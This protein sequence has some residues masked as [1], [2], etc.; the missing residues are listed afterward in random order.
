MRMVLSYGS[1]PSLALAGAEVT[2]GSGFARRGRRTLGGMA[3][4]ARVDAWLWAVRVYKSRS[5]ATSAC[6][7]GHVRVDDVRAKPATVVRPGARV[8]VSGGV[9]P[10]I[11]VVTD[12][13]SK[14]VGAA[15]A[16]QAMIDQSPPVPPK[17]ERPGPVGQRDRGAGRPTKRERRQISRLR[18]R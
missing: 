4:S 9:R 18:G 1:P 14:R 3:E 2:G 8:V 5:L 13:I 16:A 11:L 7:A 17:E 15:V 10:R 6:R 12:P